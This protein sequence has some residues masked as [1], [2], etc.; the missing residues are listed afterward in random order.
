MMELMLLI[1]FMIIIVLITDHHGLICE[2]IWLKKKTQ[3]AKNKY[4][5]AVYRIHDIEIEIS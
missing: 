1:Q 5:E 2:N 4:Q 3:S